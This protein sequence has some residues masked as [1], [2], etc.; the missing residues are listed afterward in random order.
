ME[1]ADLQVTVVGPGVYKF[2]SENPRKY[3][4][5]RE[6]IN[7]QHELLKHN[8]AQYLPPSFKDSDFFLDIQ[9]VCF[10]KNYRH[11]EIFNS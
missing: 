1:L 10:K 9:A 11:L 4:T 8:V 5:I 3:I 7:L 6:R 2:M